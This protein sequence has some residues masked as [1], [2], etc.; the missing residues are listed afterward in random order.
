MSEE[1]TQRE[2]SKVNSKEAAPAPT[3]NENAT[4]EEPDTTYVE[5]EDVI[6]PLKNTED[7]NALRK[8]SMS[9][10]TP[11]DRARGQG[12][13]HFTSDFGFHQNSSS[14]AK[15]GRGVEQEVE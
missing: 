3:E 4:G 8:L 9:N 10:P 2:I 6:E 13:T 15:S 12:A 14:A 11:T 1:T 7:S 5:N